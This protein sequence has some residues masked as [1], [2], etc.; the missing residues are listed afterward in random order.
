MTITCQKENKFSCY[1]DCLESFFKDAGLPITRQM[2]ICDFPMECHKGLNNEGEF[3]FTEGN[4][5]KLAC[6]Y[7][8]NVEWPPKATKF[9]DLQEGHFIF[10][11]NMQRQ[12]CRHVVRFSNYESGD[13]INVMDPKKG[14]FDYWTAQDFKDFDCFVFNV[15]SPAN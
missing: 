11:K 7:R 2:I 13:K 9:E 14:S 4:N 12:G 3:T 10:A 8:I 15:S 1:L 6:K 5:Q